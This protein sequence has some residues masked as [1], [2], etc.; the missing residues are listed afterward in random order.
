MSHAVHGNWDRT[1]SSPMVVVSAGHVLF[2]T[3]LVALGILGLVKGDFTPPWMAVSSV[4][5][6]REVL[7]YLSALIFLCGGL[8]L[9]WRTSAAAACRVLILFLL[10]WLVL[11]RVLSIVRAPNS[12]GG[13]WAF[14]AVSVV[15]SGAWV[16]YS[17]L[18]S[19]GGGDRLHLATGDRGR[20][21]AQRFF[22]IG[23][24]PF[25]IAHFTNVKETAVLVPSWLPGHTALAYL[26][27]AAFLAA[28]VAVFTG[29]L[30]RLATSL[31]ALQVGLFTLL[32]WGPVVMGTPNAFQWDEFV[33]SCV[34]TAMAYVV[35]ESYRGVPWLRVRTG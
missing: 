30:A 34:L 1:R 23:L 15:L 3:C 27:G 8:A 22:A 7:A 4:V 5:P 21:I 18:G 9:L 19:A 2:A 25:G 6:G 32:V 35:A 29:V 33:T 26:T 12:I 24:I 11:F 16:L 17:A 28:S 31:I 13:W 20:R 14:G 10:A